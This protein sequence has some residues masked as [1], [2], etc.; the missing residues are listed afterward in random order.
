MYSSAYWDAVVLEETIISAFEVAVCTYDSTQCQTLE[1]WILIFSVQ[2]ELDDM[3]YDFE[4]K[5]G[6]W[7]KARE[8]HENYSSNIYK[9]NKKNVGKSEHSECY[10]L[11]CYVQ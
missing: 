6:T 5:A 3:A 8:G 7:I 11:F 9:I 4:W 10:K 1:I 2:T